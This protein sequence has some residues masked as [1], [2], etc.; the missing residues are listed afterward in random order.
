[1][2][3][4]GTLRMM[5]L[6]LLSYAAEPDASGVFLIEEPENGL[7]PLAIQTVYQALAAP[8]DGVQMLCASHSPVMLSHSTLEQVLV[9]RR[10]VEGSAIVRHGREVPELVD[11]TARDNLADLF[12][13]GTGDRACTTRCEKGQ[14]MGHERAA[15]PPIS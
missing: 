8:P 5:A 3:S 1:M 13:V 6:S 7:H 15:R 9:F 11:W 10:T 14:E 2:L 12:E 4:D